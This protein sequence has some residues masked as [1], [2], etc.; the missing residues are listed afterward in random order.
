MYF[1]GIEIFRGFDRN[2]FLRKPLIPST[3][4]QRMIFITSQG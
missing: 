4:T 3:A 2:L 1:F